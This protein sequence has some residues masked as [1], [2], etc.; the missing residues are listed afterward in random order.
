MDG[1]V[2]GLGRG[3]T[4]PGIEENG[5]G[6]GTLRRARTAAWGHDF[7]PK[8]RGMT[9][10]SEGI[11]MGRRGETNRDDCARILEKDRE[12]FLEIISGGG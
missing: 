11:Y 12:Q 9:E 8:E 7:Q 1:E 10:G 2:L 5:G 4:T 6:G 3:L